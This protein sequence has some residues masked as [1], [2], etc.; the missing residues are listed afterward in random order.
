MPK[1]I[2]DAELDF[3]IKYDIKEL[4]EWCHIA[5][6]ATYQSSIWVNPIMAQYNETQEEKE[7]DWNTF[8]KV[9]NPVYRG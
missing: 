8:L 6:L 9:E 5:L 4:D 7:R 2:I 1:N 3:N